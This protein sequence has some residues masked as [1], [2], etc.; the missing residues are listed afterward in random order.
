MGTNSMT[1]LS[2]NDGIQNTKKSVSKTSVDNKKI[3]DVARNKSK[4]TN[5]KNSPRNNI[6]NEASTPNSGHGIKSSSPLKLS[7][8]R[9]RSGSGNSK[10]DR[11]VVNSNYHNYILLQKQ[12]EIQQMLGDQRSN[13]QQIT[14]KEAH[15]LC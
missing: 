7:S 3:L 2:T 15:V 11:S 1:K 8:G 6:S 14:S 9:K 4:T 13:I 10:Y 12:K 5:N